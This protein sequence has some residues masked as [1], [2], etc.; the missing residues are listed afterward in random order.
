MTLQFAQ[1]ILCLGEVQSYDYALDKVK[2]FTR[3]LLGDIVGIQKGTSRFAC[4]VDEEL[5]QSR[6][7]H[8]LDAS[9][10]Y[11]GSCEQLWICHHVPIDAPRHTGDELLGPQPAGGRAE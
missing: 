4:L 10:G 9:S 3:V 6:D 7:L 2:M 1:S 8:T 11:S 5:M